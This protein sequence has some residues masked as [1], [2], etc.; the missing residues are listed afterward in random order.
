MQKHVYPP[1]CSHVVSE[2]AAALKTQKSGLLALCA[3]PTGMALV[4]DTSWKVLPALLASV[5]H[6]SRVTEPSAHVPVVTVAVSE[7]SGVG[8]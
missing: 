5:S 8:S 7:R 3:H 2:V 4:N 1:F 6:S